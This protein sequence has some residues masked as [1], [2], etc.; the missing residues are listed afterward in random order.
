MNDCGLLIDTNEEAPSSYS[1]TTDVLYSGSEHLFNCSTVDGL[2]ADILQVWTVATLASSTA[3][4]ICFSMV[5]VKDWIQWSQHVQYKSR[6]QEQFILT[7][8]GKL[9]LPSGIITRYVGHIH[10]P[11][12]ILFTSFL[13]HSI[14]VPYACSCS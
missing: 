4:F 11:I 5:H 10:T 8:I 14:A 6:L 13:V 9:K 12:L 7:E 1:S 2:S 3:I